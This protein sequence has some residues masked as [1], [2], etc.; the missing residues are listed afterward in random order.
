MKKSFVLVIVWTF[1]ML[2]ACGNLFPT[3]IGDI[4]KDPRGYAGKEVT[5]S[6][7]VVDAFS[8]FLI[9]SFV[10]RDA[11]GEITVVTGKPLPRKGEK[12]KVTGIVKEAFSLGDQNLLVIVE[13]EK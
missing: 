4:T 1:F 5:I 9:K 6:G 7:E 3:K 11:T 13:K 2:T 12:L 8:F 10:V